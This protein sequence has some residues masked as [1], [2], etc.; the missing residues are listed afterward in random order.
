MT[1]L[2][3]QTGT[4][5][6][7]RE[8]FLV[9]VKIFEVVRVREKMLEIVLTGTG[10]REFF[11]VRVREFV[12]VLVRVREFFLEFCNSSRGVRISA[13][14]SLILCVFGGVF[15]T[16]ATQILNS[17]LSVVPSCK[18]LSSRFIVRF[19]E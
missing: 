19:L 4:G 17:T 18:H 3:L 10:K 15:Y 14:V 8:F 2:E 6:G 9:R 1:T 13:I 11:P 7:K 5:T 12:L 16:V